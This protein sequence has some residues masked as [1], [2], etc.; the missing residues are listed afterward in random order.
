MVSYLLTSSYSILKKNCTISSFFEN[1]PHQLV[2]L[3][4]DHWKPLIEYV[5]NKYDIKVNIFE[6]VIFS[7]QPKESRQKLLNEVL[8][9]NQF[10]LAGK[11]YSY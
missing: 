8:T 6:D 5:E 11:V 10:K 7:S 9:Y 2:K 1:E 4:N 3:Q